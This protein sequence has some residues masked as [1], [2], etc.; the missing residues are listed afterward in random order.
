[1]NDKLPE[2]TLEY[3]VDKLKKSAEEEAKEDAVLASLPLEQRNVYIQG[4]LLKEYA[5]IHESFRMFS[6][7]ARKPKA[8]VVKSSRPVS[9][10]EE[11]NA[12]PAK[13]KKNKK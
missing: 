7:E 13:T 12:E 5:K 4:L 2:P 8:K 6:D 9:K 1:M 10:D 11:S 3:F